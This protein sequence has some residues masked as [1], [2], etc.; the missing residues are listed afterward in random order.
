MLIIT[1]A[2]VNAVN[3]SLS[4][5]LHVASENNKVEMVDLLVSQG[6]G[7]ELQDRDGDTALDLAELQ[8]HTD[9][10]NILREK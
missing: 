10:S 3:R 5:P 9:T 6:A 4:T 2:E 8:Y 1:G 7:L